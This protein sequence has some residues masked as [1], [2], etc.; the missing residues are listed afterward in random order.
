MRFIYLLILWAIGKIKLSPKVFVD[1][2]WKICE[3]CPLLKTGVLRKYCGACQCTVSPKVGPLNKLAY[4]EEQ[5]PKGY[6]GKLAWVTSNTSNTSNTY[7]SLMYYLKFYV[8]WFLGLFGPG[9]RIEIDGLS[10]PA[11][12]DLE[13]AGIDLFSAEK[14]VLPPGEVVKVSVGVKSYF[15]PGWVALLWDRSSMGGKGLHRFGGVIDSNYRGDWK[16]CIYNST[17]DVFV[18]SRGDK[19]AQVVMQRCSLRGY[20]KVFR[21]PD[22]NRGAKGFGSTGT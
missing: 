21:L 15:R 13:A 17:N 6:W 20:K 4:P 14:L 8:F 18:I 2:R 10:W 3:S 7:E 22:S 19:I 11:Q 9:L 5:C 12:G 1:Q 16:V